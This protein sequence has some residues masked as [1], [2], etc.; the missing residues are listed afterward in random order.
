MR[1]IAFSAERVDP[2]RAVLREAR[3]RPV[4]R[5]RVAPKAQ[6]ETREPI[7]LWDL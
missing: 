3:T 1:V 5:E 2:S 6:V 4:A 7:A